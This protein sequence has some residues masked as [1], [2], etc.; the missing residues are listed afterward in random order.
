MMVYLEI[1]VIVVSGIAI[2]LFIKNLQ[3]KIKFENRVKQWLEEKEASIRE[4]AALR[5]GR[6]LSGKA[7]EKMIPLLKEFPYDPHDAKWL[8]D[9]VD[10]VIFDGYADGRDPKKIVFCEIKSGNGELSD[11]QKKIKKLVDEKKI[12]W[13]DFRVEK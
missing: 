10:F 6:V 3:W 2:I 4:D 11:H 9:P 12:E 7:L 8:G 5:S 1:L 13:F